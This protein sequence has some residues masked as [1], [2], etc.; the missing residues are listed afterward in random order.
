MS[1]KPL[2]NVHSAFLGRSI[3]ATRKAWI[4]A[5]FSI[6][7]AML[8]T[9]FLYLMLIWP[10]FM[11]AN[12]ENPAVLR[13]MQS[14]TYRDVQHSVFSKLDAYN[15]RLD[16]ESVALPKDFVLVDSPQFGLMVSLYYRLVPMPG[17]LAGPSDGTK[18]QR[19]KYDTDFIVTLAY[20]P[21]IVFVLFELLLVLVLLFALVRR[22]REEAAFEARV[23][24][25][26]FLAIAP[27]TPLTIP[28]I[29]QL[30][31]NFHTFAL[32][33]NR[34]YDGRSGFAFNDEYDV[35]DSLHA[36]L[37]LHF[38]DVRAEDPLPSRAGASARVDF[39]LPDEETIIE[40]KM[41][42][43][44]LRDKQLGEE[45]IVDIFR[46]QAARRCKRL[47][48]FVYDPQHVLVNPLGLA[49]DLMEHAQGMQVDVIFSPVMFHG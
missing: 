37:K 25:R 3:L 20:P 23:L 13:L 42:N 27:V 28:G 43:K 49:A 33:L 34:R 29:E 22:S 45:L 24:E 6:L 17:N 40:V 21:L 19:Y 18:P 14:D 26:Y 12:S 16:D 46:Y 4:F 35:Q 44:R 10:V 48:V 1:T 30:L 9:L 41:P 7:A 11:P 32:Q 38:P 47:I 2:S 36:L 39:L 31:S 8:S 15:Q 5:V